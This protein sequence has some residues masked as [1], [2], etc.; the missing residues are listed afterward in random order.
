MKS[1]IAALIA[2]VSI[3]AIGVFAEQEY[4][5]YEQRQFKSNLNELQKTTDE[6]FCIVGRMRGD[7]D[8]IRAYC[9]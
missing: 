8:L 5:A 4:K 3:I 1:A 2:A 9:K 7:R 6:S